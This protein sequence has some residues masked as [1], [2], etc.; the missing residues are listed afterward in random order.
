L[1][2]ERRAGIAD[3]SG[4]THARL[5][6]AGRICEPTPTVTCPLRRSQYCSGEPPASNH[7]AGV[8]NRDVSASDR[9]APSPVMAEGASPLVC[10]HYLRLNGNER[11]AP[12]LKPWFLISKSV[13]TFARPSV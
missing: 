7:A 9:H 10:G 2:Y 12:M 4:I 3:V 1:Q 6:T 8:G 11:P 13:M 5:Y